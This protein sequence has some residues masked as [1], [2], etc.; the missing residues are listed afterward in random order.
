MSSNVPKL[1]GAQAGRTLDTI[2]RRCSAADKRDVRT[3]RRCEDGAETEITDRAEITADAKLTVDLIF[4]A[5]A[6]AQEHEREP[7]RRSYVAIVHPLRG[8]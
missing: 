1:L 3:A 4:R 6:Q 5:A 2:T 8:V 7:D